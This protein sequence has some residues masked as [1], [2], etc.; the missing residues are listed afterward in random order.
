MLY[1]AFGAMHDDIVN[2]LGCANRLGGNRGRGKIRGSTGGIRKLRVKK[3]NG[4]SREAVTCGK[5]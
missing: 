5:F 2:T 4:I 1:T 3:W